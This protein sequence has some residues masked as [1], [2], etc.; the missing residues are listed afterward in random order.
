MIRKAV[1]PVLLTL[2]LLSAA[3]LL[4]G[5]FSQV[6]YGTWQFKYTSYANGSEQ[7][8][9]MFPMV[10]DV[11]KNGEIYLL[12]TLF[13][14]FKREKNLF[15]VTFVDDDAEE[16]EVITGAYE[17]ETTSE[18]TFLYI[19][20]DDQNIMYTLVRVSKDSNPAP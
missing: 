19:Y 14:T 12:D 9:A 5:C 1:A 10:F 16:P 7:T 13:A 17:V 20:P 6:I 18:G 15:T 2:T 11:R 4:S 8:D 3:L